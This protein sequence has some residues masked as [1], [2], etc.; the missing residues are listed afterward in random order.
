M[1][2]MPGFS[3][4]ADDA[5]GDVVADVAR[6]WSAAAERALRAG[7]PREHLVLDPGLGFYKNPRHSLD[8]CARIDELC[9]LGFPV[10]VG[11]SR[12][13]FVTRAAGETPPAPPDRRLG[14]S[15]AAAIAC[16]ERGASIVRTH[17]VAAT[18]QAL[19]VAAALRDAR[20]AHPFGEG[21]V[22]HA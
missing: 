9:A 1:A 20:L 15:V 6:E 18:R 12:K 22:G 17:D 13:S 11:P 19:A 14:G 8:L 3:M 16:V 4:Y 10:L 5:Y 2:R 7:L 21:R